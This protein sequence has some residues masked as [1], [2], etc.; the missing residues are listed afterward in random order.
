MPDLN[1]SNDL[2]PTPD[3]HRWLSVNG[4]LV[5]VTLTS[6]TPFGPTSLLAARA[7]LS[8][9]GRNTSYRSSWTDDRVR[10][11]LEQL[12]MRDT[13]SYDLGVVDG[14]AGPRTLY[15]L[16][17]YQ[18]ASRDLT[19][20]KTVVTPSPS[21]PRQSNVTSVFGPPGT[22]A[23]RAMLT[24]LPYPLRM[25]GSLSRT[26]HIPLGKPGAPAPITRIACH[27]LVHDS[28]RSIFGDIL[29]S[30]GPDQIHE[31]GLDQFAGCYNYRPMRGG[32]SLSMHAWG[33]AIDLD[34]QRN[35]LRETRATAR[36]ATPPYSHFLTIFR[37]H[38]WTSLGEERNFDWMHFQAPSL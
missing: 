33:V 7:V 6:R 28:L 11:A 37:R 23:C 30:Y 16:E 25:D 27:E 21:W 3:L 14:I 36:F 2:L 5:G 9:P 24:D 10:T 29:T 26:A 17:L 4:Q 35:Q 20:S 13:L 8:T 32:T 22:P 34:A 1:L 18:S 19:L 15:A 31:L 38:G 12:I